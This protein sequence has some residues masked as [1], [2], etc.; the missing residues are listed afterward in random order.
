MTPHSQTIVVL[1]STH[2]LGLLVD[3]RFFKLQV[4][5][6]KYLKFALPNQKQYLFYKNPLVKRLIHLYS[7]VHNSSLLP[8][9]SIQD[10]FLISFFVSIFIVKTF[11]FKVCFQRNISPENKLFY[12]SFKIIDQMYDLSDFLHCNRRSNR[13]T[14]LFIRQSFCNRQ[15]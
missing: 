3:I 11:K 2:L 5:F 15:R 13:N 6:Y 14:Q 10:T 1:S 7:L 12:L 9:L 8:P 4:F